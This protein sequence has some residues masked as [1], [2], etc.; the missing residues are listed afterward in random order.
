LHFHTLLV[1]IIGSQHY[2]CKQEIP[3]RHSGSDGENRP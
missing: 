3:T 2:S 1:D